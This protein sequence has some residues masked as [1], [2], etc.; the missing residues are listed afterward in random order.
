[1]YL[2]DCFKFVIWYS[3]IPEFLYTFLIVKCFKLF[4]L[5]CEV[6]TFSFQFYLQL[7]LWQT[8]SEEGRMD[9]REGSPR[10][11]ELKMLCYEWEICSSAPVKGAGILFFKFLSFSKLWMFFIRLLYKYIYIVIYINIYIYSSFQ[12]VQ[13]T[14]SRWHW[15]FFSLTCPYLNHYLFVVLLKS[16]S[17]HFLC[18]HLA[19]YNCFTTLLRDRNTSS[20]SQL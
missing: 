9:G 20:T 12:K 8:P 4:Q 3:E 18:F 16:C 1:M 6:V 10:E 13:F 17:I 2:E 7:G 15:G 14:F 11:N 5:S 19:S